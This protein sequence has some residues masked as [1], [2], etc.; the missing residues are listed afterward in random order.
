[1]KRS[2]AVLILGA[3]AVGYG[4]VIALGVAVLEQR[5]ELN[6]IQ[7][8]L[9]QVS[10]LGSPQGSPGARSSPSPAFSNLLK[11]T[12]NLGHVWLP[13]PNNAV[14]AV[15]AG[16]VFTFTASAQDPLNRPLE[17]VFFTGRAPSVNVVCGWGA[18]T[19][20]W[21]AQGSPG[22]LRGGAL[23]GRGRVPGV[24]VPAAVLWRPSPSFLVRQPLAEISRAAPSVTRSGE[25]T[26][27]LW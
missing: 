10:T 20:Q 25:F 16:T 22:D 19:C 11:V 14:L 12:D 13:G 23:E 1:M 2:S 4:A 18:S 15:K 9:A 3:L 24:R 27:I 17:Y 7:A 8:R 5:S 21:T 26:H 6:S